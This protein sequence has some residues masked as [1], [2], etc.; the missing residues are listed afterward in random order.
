MGLTLGVPHTAR[1]RK[2]P[3]QEV[4]RAHTTHGPYT[5]RLLP[6]A[7]PRCPSKQVHTPADAGHKEWQQK[8]LLHWPHHSH[9][10]A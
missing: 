3:A 4:I 6:P 5:A 7:W 10:C 9:C 1:S 2:G 8:R